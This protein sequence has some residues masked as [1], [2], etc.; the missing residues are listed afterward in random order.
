MSSGSEKARSN[1]KGALILLFA[2]VIWGT[3]FVAQSQ[4]ME[5]IE[6]FTFNGIRTLMGAAF[7]LIYLFLRRLISGRGLDGAERAARR[8]KTVRSVKSGM[9]VGVFLFVASNLQQFAFNETTAGKIAFIT[10]L[11][12]FF[13]PVF[14]LFLGKRPNPL[15]WVCVSAG[16]L[17]LYFLSI[18]PAEPW[19]I[20][21][22]DF[23][24]LLCAIA[25]AVHI[26]AVE[27]FAADTD[28]VTLS[29]TQFTVSGVV[30]CLMMFLFETPS[31][32]DIHA[33]ILPL[34]S[35]GVM[36][37][38][39]AFTLQVIGQKYA[40]ATVAS[41]AMCMESVFGVIS[42]ALILGDR[43]SG[44][45]TVGCVLM[46]AAITFSQVSDLLWSRIRRRHAGERSVS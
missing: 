43:M 2:S 35:S 14:G 31:I 24:A 18:D 38:G 1:V 23:L 28:G 45:E 10:A 19:N 25:Y 34:L 8:E 41:L 11:Y 9:I 16:F 20:N 46:F 30:S 27:H 33:V 36:S 29:F 39:I 37:C 6:A 32:P 13:V 4:G 12:M 40:E 17:G 22:G 3:S 5:R 42:A 26:L 7:L 44:R 15:V 21:R